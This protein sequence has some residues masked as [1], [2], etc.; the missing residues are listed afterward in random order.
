MLSTLSATSYDRPVNPSYHIDNRTAPVF[1][2]EYSETDCPT[3]T[4]TET[5]PDSPVRLTSGSSSNN[6][7]VVN[8][9]Q[10]TS[11]LSLIARENITAR[12]TPEIC[13]DPGYVAE[14]ETNKITA[15][16]LKFKKAFPAPDGPIWFRRRASGN[17]RSPS[18]RGSP[19]A[20]SPRTTPKNSR[21]ASPAPRTGSNSWTPTATSRTLASSPLIAPAD[22]TLPSLERSTAVVGSLLHTSVTLSLP[23][24]PTRTP[25][26]P[27][28]P[29]SFDIPLPPRPTISPKASAPG[30]LDV[31]S[32]LELPAPKFIGSEQQHCL[33][34]QPSHSVENPAAPCLLAALTTITRSTSTS[35]RLPPSSSSSSSVL[36]PTLI[37]LPKPVQ[38]LSRCPQITRQLSAHHLI[39]P[40]IKTPPGLLPVGSSPTQRSST[41]RT[42]LINHYPRLTGTPSP[43]RRG[44]SSPLPSPF[45]SSPSGLELRR[46]PLDMIPAM[47]SQHSPR[48]RNG[49]LPPSWFIPRPLSPATAAVAGILKA[50]PIAMSS[51]GIDDS[52]NGHFNPY[53][54]SSPSSPL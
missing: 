24:P 17:S 48:D 15:E 45:A 16:K 6:K 40:P 54:P 35:K 20:G 49:V 32:P 13:D 30:D 37:P 53:F 21:P 3:E 19:S 46:V 5:P 34:S 43:R 44:P 23:S 52:R 1:D 14:G 27:N 25:S 31:L 10:A 26:E 4:E 29:V 18:P 33:L 8:I 50:E 11:A 38:P 51:S 7:P 22:Q 36:T 9:V 2:A 12:S 42:S 47:G 28:E 41:P 39:V